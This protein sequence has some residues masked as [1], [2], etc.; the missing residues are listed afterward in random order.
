MQN[1]TY[2]KQPSHVKIECL[3][4]IF[5]QLPVWN[6]KFQALI[7]RLKTYSWKFD[8]EIHSIILMPFLWC[9]IA[10][11]KGNT[12]NCK[13]TFYKSWLPP[14][15]NKTKIVCKVFSTDDI[16]V[17]HHS[18]KKKHMIRLYMH[19]RCYIK[20]TRALN[21]MSILDL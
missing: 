18:Q 20:S 15:E 13:H 12:V 6:L 1:E 16:L 4:S 9:T 17:V 8:C 7:S 10:H 21:I 3:I 2:L 5:H 19:C 14:M 11:W